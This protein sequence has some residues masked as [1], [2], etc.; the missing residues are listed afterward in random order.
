MFIQN[1]PPNSFPTRRP[2]V[3]VVDRGRFTTTRL[4]AHVANI[5]RFATLVYS[6]SDGIPILTGF[7]PSSR[8]GEGACHQSGILPLV[9]FASML[10]TFR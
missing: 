7:L 5:S 4:L 6:N 10:G 2:S 9:W 8:E 1:H 3:A